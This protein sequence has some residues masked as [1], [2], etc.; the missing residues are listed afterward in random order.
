MEITEVRIVLKTEHKLKAFVRNTFDNYFVTRGLKVI[1][2]SQWYFVS[3][4][5]LN[6]KNGRFLD[7]AHPI[8]TEMRKK[9]EDK[10]LDAFEN[11]PNRIGTFANNH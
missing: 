5:G 1:N 10:I 8:N 9:I 7:L 2:G 4:P 3:I 6:L 11:E